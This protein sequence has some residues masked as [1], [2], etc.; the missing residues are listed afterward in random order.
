M[1][2]RILKKPAVRSITGLCDNT[3]REMESEGSFPKRFT[4]GEELLLA[5][6]TIVSLVGKAFHSDDGTHID[7]SA[8]HR[9]GEDSAEKPYSARGGALATPH[10]GAAPLPV[11][12][13]VAVLPWATSC[14]NFFTSAL[15]TS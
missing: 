4:Q 6:V 1:T 12:T 11:L 2:D 9:I 10:N 15:V 14:K 7:H 8:I 5:Q 13:P 3:L